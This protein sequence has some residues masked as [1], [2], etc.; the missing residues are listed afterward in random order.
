M[1]NNAWHSI[2]WFMQYFANPLAA[3]ALLVV[4]G[5]YA[6][7]TRRILKANEDAVAETRAMVAATKDMADATRSMSEVSQKAYLASLF[8]RI[9][10]ASSAGSSS[11]EWSEAHA[12]IQNIGDHVLKLLA[13][14][15]EVGPSAGETIEQREDKELLPRRSA[16]LDV[17]VKKPG[18]IRS[19]RAVFEDIAGQVHV[20]ALERTP[21]DRG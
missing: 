10:V 16:S 6:R 4:T 18:G 21:D 5:W 1:S 2:E 15:A 12:T 20:V 14:R 17:K 11:G 8:P 3:V 13:L 7:T 19:V 9:R